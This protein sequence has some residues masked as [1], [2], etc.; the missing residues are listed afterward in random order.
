MAVRLPGSVRSSN[1]PV[2]AGNGAQWQPRLGDKAT[3][4][5]TARAWNAG[6]IA[7]ATGAALVLLAALVVLGARQAWAAASAA[8]ASAA[9]VARTGGASG[10]GR[11]V[12]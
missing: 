3:L 2:Q 7:L 12:R 1:A 10:A 4:N 6:H 9:R 8:A 5:A 11:T